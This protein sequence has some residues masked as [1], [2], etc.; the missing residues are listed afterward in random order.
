MLRRTVP[1][2]VIVS[3]L[4]AICPAPSRAMSTQAEIALGQSEDQQIV[5]SSVI[6]TDPLLNAYVQGVAGNLWNQVQR[7][8]VPYSIKIIKDSQ[9]NSFATVGG[10]VY[11]NEGLIDF[12]Q[13][14]DELAGVVGHETGHIERR[15]VLTANSKAEIL[16]ILFGIA[17]IF[18]PILYEFG[19]LAEAGL[20]MKISREDEIQADRYGLL[21]MS[22]AGYDPE[23]MVTIMAHLGVLQDEH[24]DAVSK[25]LEDH[26]D[27]KARVAHLMGYPELDPTEVTP[28]QQLVQASS[29]EERA[30][31]DFARL[32][33]DQVLAKDPQ[34]SEALLELGQSE[35]ALGLPNKSE[36]TLAEAA[37]LG[38]PLT[39]ATANQRIAALRAME[40]K[41][42]TLTKP[43]L[44]KLQ[45]MVQAAQA[46]QLADA[47]QISDRA[48]EGKGQVKSVQSRLET[49]QYEIPDFSR[50]N[51]HRGSRVEAVVK[52]I[53]SIARSINST[54]EDAGSDQ[55]P[56]GGIGS[57]EKNKESGLLKESA[58]IY[59]EMLEPLSM[60]PVPAESVAI[61][62]SYPSMMNEL[63]LADG[64]MLRSVDAARA[65]LTMLDQSLGDLDEFLKELDRAQISFNGDISPTEYATLAPSM[66]KNVDEFNAAATAASQGLQLFNLA[67]SRQLSTR[68]TL[69]G[70][71]TSPQLYSTL[72]YALQQRFGSSGIDYRTMLR[73][74]LTPG[75]VAAA[76]I[77]AAD[78]KS[79]PE[80]VIAE[81]KSS[82]QTVIDV[83]N[84]HK[85]HAWPLEIFMGLVYLDYTDDPAKELR[86][87]DGTLAIDLDKLGL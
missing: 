6:E 81:A 10:F 34:S 25:Y 19:G 38:S 13:S 7:K 21:L 55:S 87:A 15:H 77:I 30:R 4:C 73:D 65:S 23:A 71:G 59:T 35:L 52:N 86:K 46:A 62:P 24:D 53:T 66:R 42:V 76:T 12:V 40:V 22:R 20:M 33:L 45:S 78:I 43:N 61:L 63:T 18:S 64:D 68:I 54:L 11:V 85:M 1:I 67:R 44:P 37:Q 56:I 17:S 48:A 75:D 28:A 84:S 36:Q 57:L 2:F 83:A 8:D 80:S 49:L 72:Q 16:D 29:D 3:L 47:T 70:L 32:R 27:P 5:A 31:Y 39:R 41:Q 26:P 82:N 69:L 51:I 79:T 50:I 58:D 60:N 14:D 74:D 9:V